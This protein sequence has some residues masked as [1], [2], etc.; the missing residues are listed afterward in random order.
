MPS[1]PPNATTLY[2]SL[3]Q[4]KSR[5]ANSPTPSE[6]ER[7]LSEGGAAAAMFL[8][9]P[10]RDLSEVALQLTELLEWISD[11]GTP[12][13]I[14]LTRRILADVERMSGGGPANRRETSVDAPTGAAAEP[15]PPVFPASP[16]QQPSRPAFTAAHA[17]VD[18]RARP[19][20]FGG[21]VYPSIIAASRA[22]N[23][24]VNQLRRV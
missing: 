6:R 10:A 9:E 17:K 13:Q 23:I 22:T 2:A 21:T 8:R 24:P 3:A 12:S 4:S 20:T 11:D 18:R 1:R 14:E 15:T 7:F 16:S 5:W 19:V